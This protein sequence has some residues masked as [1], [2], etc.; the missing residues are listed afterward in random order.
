MI[1]VPIQFYGGESFMP[2]P[3][4]WQIQDSSGCWIPF[5]LTGYTATFTARQ[6][7]PSPDPPFI[8]ATTENGMISIDG[9]AGAVQ[10][11]LPSNYTSTLV[12]PFCGIWDLW[13]Y[14]PSYPVVA[15]RLVGG[16][17]N[18]LEAVTRL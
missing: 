15:Y 17:I 14:S 13:V 16:I 4:L 11:I 12:V 9:P 10:I 6:T 5:D 18:V 7:V 3:V 8:D 1:S 2:P